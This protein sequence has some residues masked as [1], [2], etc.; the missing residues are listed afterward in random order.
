MK[1]AQYAVNPKIKINIIA[2]LIIFNAHKATKEIGTKNNNKINFKLYKTFKS[3]LSSDVIDF[4]TN[5]ELLPKSVPL[6]NKVI[7]LVNNEYFPKSSKLNVLATA[8]K[9][10]NPKTVL[11]IFP[12][13]T[14]EIFI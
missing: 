10:R 4:A 8:V 14:N 5:K 7:K 11:K 2:G 13:L 6:A 3:F 12:A 1:F 9:K